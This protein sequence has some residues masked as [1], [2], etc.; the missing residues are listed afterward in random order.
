[1][2]VVL[3]RVLKALL[4]T[5]VT[6][7]PATDSFVCCITFDNLTGKHDAKNMA[8]SAHTLHT[9]VFYVQD[10][11]PQSSSHASIPLVRWHRRTLSVPTLC[12][13][14]SRLQESD[15][16]LHST[17]D[18]LAKQR[19]LQQLSTKQS[20]LSV[21]PPVASQQQCMCTG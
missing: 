9:N 12:L 3:E 16:L 6:A 17:V 15:T 2:H 19:S 20:S 8:T 1:M 11:Q 18:R 21:L 13:H 5:P 14:K 4:L 7:S 10:N